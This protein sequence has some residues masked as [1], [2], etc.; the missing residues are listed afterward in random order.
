MPEKIKKETKKST[1]IAKPKAKKAVKKIV[2]KISPKKKP[3]V[4]KVVKKKA[5]TKKK[6]IK[7]NKK[8][9]K[10]WATG[11]RK[12]SVARVQ[13]FLKGQG[14]ISVN[15][16]EVKEYFPIF[17]LQEK[18]WIPLKILGKE[19]DFDFKITVRGGGVHGQAD[20]VSLGIARALVFIEP[21]WRK[22][23]KSQSLLRRDSRKKERKKPGL[24]RA[25]RAPQWKKR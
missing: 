7:T 23:L 1:K 2:K 10:I 24:K 8:E 14:N 12:T 17:E 4:K 15:K 13:C 20:A 21:N 22:D 3:A 18:V 19:K 16:K 6:E 9:E 5:E 11:K 25:R